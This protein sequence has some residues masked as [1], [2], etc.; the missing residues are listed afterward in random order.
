MQR[1]LPLAILVIQVCHPAEQIRQT[2]F[3]F[4]IG[5]PVQGSAITIVT[6][7]QVKPSH[8]EEIEC[9]RLVTL[10]RNMKHI[11]AKFVS[12]VDISAHVQQVL[13]SV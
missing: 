11:D 8:L 13:T 5:G 10:S 7:A 9:L 2:N 1:C 3:S 12:R 4:N 6:A